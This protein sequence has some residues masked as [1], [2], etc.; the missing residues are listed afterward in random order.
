MYWH[1]TIVNVPLTL[2]N[3][4]T[5]VFILSNN[6]FVLV[7]CLNFYMHRENV[8]YAVLTALDVVCGNIW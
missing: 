2:C 4:N 1:K 8:L 7:A 3:G 5:W 6:I